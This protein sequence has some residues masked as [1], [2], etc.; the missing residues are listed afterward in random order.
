MNKK[1][2]YTSITTAALFVGTQ[3]GVNNAQ[4]DTATDN[5][6]TTN[7]TSATQGS[8]QTATNEKLATVKPTSQ[9]QYQANVQTAKGNVVT[10]QNQVN[11]TQAKVATAQGQVTNQSQLVAI[12]QSQYDAG[13]ARVDRAQ[14]TLDANNQV[15][16]EAENKVDAA[17]SQ[18][19]A[20]ETQIPADQQQ[21]AA[22]KVAIA[23]Q[24]ATEKKAQTAKDAA[25]TALTQAKTEQATA[26]SDADAASAVTAAKQAT[27][28][29]ASA[30]QQKAATQANQAKVAVASA[31][32]AVNKNT[33]AINS[34]KTAI[35]NTTSQ[36]NANNQAVSTAQAKV[37][38]AQA[39][40]AAA[41]RP[42][43]TTES[44]NKYDA[45]EFPQSQLTGAETVSVA[46]PSNGKYVPNADKINQYMFEYI[47]QLRALNGQPALKQTATLQN[48][49]IARA[50]AQVD[51]GL[52][53]T[54]SSYAENLTQVYPQWFMSDQETAYNAVMGWYDESNNIESGS[55]GHRVNLIYSTGDAGV[56]INLAKHVAAFEVDNAGMTEAQ[57]D[58]YV[59]LFDNAHANAATGTKALPAVTFNYVQT[60]PADPKKIAA[61]NATLIAATASL[62]GLQNTGKTLATTLANQNASLQALQNQT[63]GLQATV[64]TKQAQ[65]QVAATSLKAANV[66]LTQAQGQLA[67]A[68]QQQLS[69][70]RNLKTAIAKTAAA[71][72]TATQAA[73]NLA[74]AKTLVADLTAEN[75]R[76]A[77]VLAQGQ[78]QVDTANEQ[79]AAGKAQL[80]RKKTDLAQFK[81][82][83]GAARVDLAVAQGDLTATKAFLARVEANKFTTT[84]AAAA[85]GIA[86][87]TNVDQSTGVTA[88]HATATKTVANSN[89]TIN[90][91]STSVDVS[92]GDVTTKLVAGAKQQ[93][94]AAQATALPQT[95]EKQSASLTVVGLL[96]AG[97]SL[98]GLTK[99]RKR[100]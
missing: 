44:Q 49:A 5:S 45:A 99:L 95:D 41:E 68:Q 66:A 31:Q 89:G 22:N 42:T 36:I 77:A 57:Q 35:Q 30:A 72:V 96:A 69:P 17:K 53:H 47:N 100:A 32:D 62:N 78:A 29:Q 82:V 88:P 14:Q 3:L 34:A 24:P 39:A 59:D 48:N 50:A 65:V 74:S 9:Q 25:V 86:E 61:A 90:A 51:G 15:L 8:A 60:A 1:L 19:A 85:D 21:I 38:A 46:Y 4:A 37:T 12:G 13:K 27:V 70:V 75:A 64:T 33:Q 52:D 56:A 20:A 84:T 11:T 18:T 28:D 92:D 81:Q 23:N 26:Q 79:L 40:L 55:F 73:K 71:Q 97:F 87:T 63:S 93:P 94:V 91:T 98:L 10:A 76:L 7:Q 16:A 80:D 6:D 54:G 43:T 2:L 67:M 83:L 58:K